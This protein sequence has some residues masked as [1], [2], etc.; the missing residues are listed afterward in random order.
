MSNRLHGRAAGRFPAVV[1]RVLRLLRTNRP[2]EGK[3]PCTQEDAWR[4]TALAGF[5]LLMVAE[6]TCSRTTLHE[7]LANIAFVLARPEIGV[8]MTGLEGAVDAVKL[9]SVE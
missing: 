7:S 1:L 8:A 5:I 2:T 4:V 6:A 9:A 3:H